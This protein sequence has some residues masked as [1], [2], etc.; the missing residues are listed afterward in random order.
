MCTLH[1]HVNSTCQ[2]VL[3]V[4]FIIKPIQFTRE[5]YLDTNMSFKSMPKQDSSVINQRKN[6]ANYKSLQNMFVSF[7]L[8]ISN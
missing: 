5:S 7:S 3:F 6:T 4:L 1:H 2:W 8:D